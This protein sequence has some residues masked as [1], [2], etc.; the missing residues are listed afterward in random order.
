MP[1]AKAL[2][3][4]DKNFLEERRVDLERF[5]NRIQ[6]TKEFAECM[7]F[8]MFL[9]RPETTFGEGKKSV[10]ENMDMNT[11]RKT[12]E[13]LQNMYPSLNELN[14]HTSAHSEDIPRLKDVCLSFL[15]Y[16]LPIPPTLCSF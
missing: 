4:F 2:G 13:I 8:R 3:R 11:H 6:E 1:P 5:L 7:L 15:F 14:L 9:A 16:F 12:T 10:E